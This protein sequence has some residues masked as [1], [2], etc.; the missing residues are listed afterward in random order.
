MNRMKGINTHTL[1]SNCLGGILEIKAITNIT[2]K[3][4]PKSLR[5]VIGVSIMQKIMARNEIIF[6]LGSMF[7]SKLLVR[8]ISYV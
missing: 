3:Y 6:D 1:L 2:K 4:S 8:F 5:R 7:S